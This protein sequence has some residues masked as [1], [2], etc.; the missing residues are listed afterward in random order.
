MVRAE[1][2]RGNQ[3]LETTAVFCV[4]EYFLYGLR[5]MDTVKNKQFR[6]LKSMNPWHF[7]W[8]SVVLSELCALA[9]NISPELCVVGLFVL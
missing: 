1:R 4:A 2:D 9:A 8:I 7:L 5:A 3:M 6:M